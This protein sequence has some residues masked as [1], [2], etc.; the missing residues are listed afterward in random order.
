MAEY[1]IPTTSKVEAL[2]AA[3]SNALEKHGVS[4]GLHASRPAAGTAGRYYFST[5][6]K[7]WSRDNGTTWDELVTGLSESEVLALIAD[8]E[9]LSEAAQDAI[10]KRHAAPV[11]DA[12]EDE[13]VFTI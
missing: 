13:L 12:E 2:I 1:R 3:H 10:A 9:N 7:T 8:D 6:T 11:Y 4:A 5:D